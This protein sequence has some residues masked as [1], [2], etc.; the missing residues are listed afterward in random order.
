MNKILFVEAKVDS[1]LG[2]FR[3]KKA[4]MEENTVS[5]L[6]FFGQSIHNK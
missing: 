1:L 5:L 3:E 2:P 4:Q 6:T